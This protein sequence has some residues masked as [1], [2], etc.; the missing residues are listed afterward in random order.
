M[1]LCETVHNPSYYERYHTKIIGHIPINNQQ[2]IYVCIHEIMGLIIMKMKMEIR[3]RSH[4]Y[5]INRPTSRHDTIILNI[6]NV[7]V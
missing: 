5:V 1:K 2:N 6:K 4:R 7:S 3:K